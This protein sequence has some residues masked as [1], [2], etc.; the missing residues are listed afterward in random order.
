MLKC[1]HCGK[2]SVTGYDLSYYGDREEEKTELMH[3]CST[4]CLARW[5]GERG[6]LYELYLRGIHS[7][8]LD[9]NPQLHVQLNRLRMSV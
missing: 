9:S 2:T 8:E 3:F 7:K 6:W 4:H 5:I 1:T